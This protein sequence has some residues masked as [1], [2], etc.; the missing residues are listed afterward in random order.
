M[1][2]VFK[3]ARDRKRPGSSWF[4]A[5]TDE[6]GVRRMVKG[7]PDK[8]ATEALARKLESEAELRRRGVIHPRTDAYAAHEARPLADHLAEWRAVMLAR[9]MSTRHADQYHAR[10]ARVVALA[11]GARLD[12]IDTAGRTPEAV[13]GAARAL[14]D[15]VRPARLSDLTPERVQTALARLRAGGKSNQTVDHHRAAAR[16]FCRWACDTGRLR[17][18]PMRG[19]KGFNPEEVRRHR[20]RALTPDEAARLIRAAERG[21]VVRGMTGPD[22]ARLYAL[23]LGTGLRASEL[24]S[25]TPGRFDL[26]ADPRTVT[27][28]AAYTKNG[29]EAVQP[30]PRPWPPGWP[31]GSRPWPRAARCLTRCRPRRPR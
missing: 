23:A 7:C 19:V 29:K 3:K 6:S 12:D 24:A 30:L 31:P 4:I 11:R 13:A 16:A 2:S 25:L 10:A 22:R 15:A 1:S 18:N 27:V 20:R 5:Y 21:P 17:D 28:P 8:A 26:A 14:A 9:G